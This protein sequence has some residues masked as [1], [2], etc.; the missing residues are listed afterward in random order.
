MAKR[1][2]KKLI[3]VLIRGSAGTAEGLARYLK[4]FAVGWQ[5]MFVDVLHFAHELVA[6]GGDLWKLDQTVVDL[7]EERPVFLAQQ[8]ELSGAGPMCEGALGKIHRVR[9]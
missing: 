4:R 2:R 6:A 8:P 3:D 1:R 7:S 5:R 9:G